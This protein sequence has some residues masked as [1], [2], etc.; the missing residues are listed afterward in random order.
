MITKVKT[1]PQPDGTCYRSA[2]YLLANPGAKLRSARAGLRPPTQPPMV[3]TSSVSETPNPAIMISMKG[4]YF[5]TLQLFTLA[6]RAALP[7][8]ILPVPILSAPMLPTSTRAHLKR[9]VF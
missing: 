5:V 7:V 9:T 1:G 2:V 3:A 8:A 4:V 6:A